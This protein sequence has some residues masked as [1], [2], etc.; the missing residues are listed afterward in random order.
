ME[1]ATTFTTAKDQEHT[2]EKLF[3]RELNSPNA[4][5]T[6]NKSGIDKRLL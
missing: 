6:G 4:N 3:A 1:P 5:D 2:T